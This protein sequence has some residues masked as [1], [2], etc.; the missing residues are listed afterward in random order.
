MLPLPSFVKMFPLGMELQKIEVSFGIFRKGQL[1][2]PELC[3]YVLELHVKPHI[4][5]NLSPLKACYPGYPQNA[6][7]LHIPLIDIQ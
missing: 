5:M 6:R 2:G 3:S 1:L 7:T 4:F